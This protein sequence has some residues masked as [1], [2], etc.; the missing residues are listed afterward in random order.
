MARCETAI[1]RREYKVEVLKIP[2]LE[3]RKAPLLYT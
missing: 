3:K 1:F 2:G